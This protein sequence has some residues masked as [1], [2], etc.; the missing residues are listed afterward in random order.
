MKIICGTEYKVYNVMTLILNLAERLFEKLPTLP[1][2][3]AVQWPLKCA[4]T[5][6]PFRAG[7]QSWT[8]LA[9]NLCPWRMLRFGYVWWYWNG[10]RTPSVAP[11]TRSSM[12]GCTT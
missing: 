3:R 7:Y 8:F 5:Q 10:M 11:N 1:F 2:A 9:P 6:P 12:P 4:F